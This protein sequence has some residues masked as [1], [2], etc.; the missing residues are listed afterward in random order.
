M[1]TF[2]ILGIVFI[3]FAMYMPWLVYCLGLIFKGHG[4]AGTVLAMSPIFVF[5]IGLVLSH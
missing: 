2:Q 3:V 4:I 5:G 1:S